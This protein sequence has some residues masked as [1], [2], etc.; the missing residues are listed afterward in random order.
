M[1][2]LKLVE[3]DFTIIKH[4]FAKNANKYDF[5]K[6]L[7]KFRKKFAIPLFEIGEC[8]YENYNFE[9]II[10]DY[11]DS[12]IEM[13]LNIDKKDETYEIIYAQNRLKKYKEY[14]EEYFYFMELYT[15]GNR[16][17]WVSYSHY[18]WTLRCEII[19]MKIKENNVLRF[20]YAQQQSGKDKQILNF[21]DLKITNNSK[22]DE[23]VHFA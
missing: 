11:A 20:I 19:E 3:S 15:T 21:V 2:E 13:D 18:N 7:P 8:I 6:I 16:V 9:K 17:K 12:I 22:F 23:I 14:N 1:K 10:D 4:N 5:V